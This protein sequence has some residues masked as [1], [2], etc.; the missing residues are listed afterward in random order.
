[1][2][3]K[4]ALRLRGVDVGDPRLP[5]LPADRRSRWRAITD[6]LAEAGVAARPARTTLLAVDANG[7]A[8][9]VP[10]RPRRGRV[11]RCRPDAATV[12]RV[13]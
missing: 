7:G 4:A 2:F 12:T 1:M 3:S 6:D 10:P 8:A 11:P 13:S 9:G 5:L